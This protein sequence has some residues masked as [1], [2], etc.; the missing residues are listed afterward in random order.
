MRTSHTTIELLRQ[1][2]KAM[3]EMVDWMIENLGEHEELDIFHWTGPLF[4]V[5]AVDTRIG[6]FITTQRFG[7]TVDVAKGKILWNDESHEAG[8]TSG[9]CF[10]RADRWKRKERV[11]NI[12]QG[13]I[14]IY[15]DFRKWHGKGQTN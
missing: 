12:P 5:E 14:N 4:Y 6:K 3:A 15:K 2:S 10:V 7:L 1:S 13:K 9:N 8:P 11:K